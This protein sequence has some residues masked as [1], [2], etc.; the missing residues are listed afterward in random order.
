MNSIHSTATLA[1][2]AGIV[3]AMLA[4]GAAV[5]VPVETDPEFASPARFDL[6]LSENSLLRA[7]SMSLAAPADAVLREA[8]R[9]LQAGSIA[10]SIAMTRQ[11][12]AS[13]P[14]SAAAHE[15]LGASLII[16]GKIDEGY[17]ELLRAIQVDPRQSSAHVKIGDVL[18][19][20]GDIA[21]AKRSYATAVGLDP[22]DR[23]PQ[24]RLGLIAEREGDRARA[25]EY[26]ERGI[27][28]TPAGYVGVRANL[29]RLYNGQGEFEKARSVLQAPL[30]QRTT[31][32]N[33]H[34]VLG[35]SLLGLGRVDEALGQ[36]EF[37]VQT[38]PGFV[39]GQLGLGIASRGN[40]DFARS[41]RALNE[42]VRLE[43]KWSTGHFQLGETYLA[44]SRPTEAIP[45]YERALPLSPDPRLIRRRIADAHVAAGEY[46]K[47]IPIY[48][49]LAQAKDAGPLVLA[50]LGSA[51]QL[52]GDFARARAT[53]ER[54]VAERPKDPNA[55]LLL[56]NHFGLTR[57]YRSAISA[58]E[59]GLRI[60]PRH[61]PLL[62]AQAL[63]YSRSGQ[64]AKAA[65]E[66][67]RLV[68]A[69]P[70]DIEA[71]F[72]RASLRDEAGQQDAA[73][74]D[75]RRILAK[76]PGHVGANNNLA[77]ILS[78]QGQN[79]EALRYA[80]R[81]RE[82]APTNPMVLDTNGLV[83]LNAGRVSEAVATLQQAARL[84]PLEPTIHYRLGAA[85]LKSGNRVAAA[86]SLRKALELNPSFP[87][88]S[89]ARALL[90][91]L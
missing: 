4:A 11:Y 10:E 66:A 76:A 90:E 68:E 29:A 45:H 50:A 59:D 15:L 62:N 79:D 51:H 27:V 70:G 69:S 25:I 17:A 1:C 71:E 47:A 52:N 28:G 20:R 34:V 6:E 78:R 73:A 57:D 67:Q 13:T 36:F 42:V 89:D 65:D 74:A 14:G 64:P 8:L 54:N 53:F 18:M 22:S 63:A 5:A 58:Y 80:R 7:P 83:E 9:L 37:A 35:T 43:P 75:Y 88:A 3:V 2:V 32:A 48:E 87:E 86:T 44:M 61:A 23:F 85:Q 33:A 81:A 38:D 26:Y 46:G 24:Q 19:T 91:G 55:Y 40:R 77:M 21:G 31:D 72:L 39:G 56:G 49:S 12:V 16:Q 30:G 84:A 60:A 82:G 41:L